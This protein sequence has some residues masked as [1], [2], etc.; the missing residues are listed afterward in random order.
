MS[1]T[2]TQSW[3]TSLLQPTPSAIL[4][5]IFVVLSIPLFL[6][7][8]I[9]RSA[10]STTQPSILLV[11]PSGSGKTSLLTLVHSPVPDITYRQEAI[12]ELTAYSLSAATQRKP[13]LPKPP[14]QSKYPSPSPH[15]PHP[16]NIDLSTTPH[17]KYTNDSYSQTLPAMASYAIM[18]STAS[19]SHKT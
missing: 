15:P 3:L 14:L 10:S 11:G 6:H 12:A 1:W 18:L 17:S 9:Y 7:L 16:P 4:I 13:A 2:G 5:T 19:S 8:Y